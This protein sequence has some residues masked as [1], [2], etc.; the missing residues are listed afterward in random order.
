MTYGNTQQRVAEKLKKLLPLHQLIFICEITAETKL[1]YFHQTSL[2]AYIYTLLNCLP[3]EQAKTAFRILIPE[4]GRTHYNKGDSYHFSILTFNHGEQYLNPLIQALEHGIPGN[5]RRVWHNNLKIT[6][7]K[8]GF[9]QQTITDPKQLTPYTLSD[10]DR[11]AAALSTNPARL[12]IETGI[13]L[14]PR[15]LSCEDFSDSRLL[16][17]LSNAIILSLIHI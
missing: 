9:S 2:P 15:H 14:T 13:M 6:Q 17:Q 5:D 16:Q 1:Q 8:D 11:E 3:P 7:L 12:L 10:L 4:S